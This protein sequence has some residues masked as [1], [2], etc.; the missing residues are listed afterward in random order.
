MIR[1]ILRRK[2]S[3]H[4]VLLGATK[5]LKHILLKF[6]LTSFQVVGIVKFS[7][8]GYL[9]EGIGNKLYFM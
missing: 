6:A 5:D 7:C 1:A 3:N 8:H 4:N 2:K 9:Q